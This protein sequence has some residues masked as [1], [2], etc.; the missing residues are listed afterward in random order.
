MGP[1]PCGC[2]VVLWVWREWR[3]TVGESLQ[4]RPPTKVSRFPARTGRRPAGGPREALRRW[5][6]DPDIWGQEK[7]V[8]SRGAWDYEAIMQAVA[9]TRMR[10]IL[11][12]R[13]RPGGR[14]P[15]DPPFSSSRGA[16]AP[17]TPRS[18]GRA[19]GG[20]ISRSI[21]FE[22][23]EFVWG[24]T[25]PG[26]YLIFFLVKFHVECRQNHVWGPP[27]A[28]VMSIFVKTYIF[29]KVELR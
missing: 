20:P 1:P 2:G 19:G 7:K 28:R 6:W 14:C 9:P 13:M 17:R 12:T 4:T 10:I 22:F 23:L 27:G 8:A 26:R 11:K 18:G 25:G 24:S 15:P 5:P 21:F 3:G 16:A 29:G